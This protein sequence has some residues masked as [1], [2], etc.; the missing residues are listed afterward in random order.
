[1]EKEGRIF[2]AIEKL[3]RVFGYKLD[4]MSEDITDLTKDMVRTEEN[5][6][7]TNELRD[8]ATPAQFK[9]GFKDIRN[10]KEN[11]QKILGA[12]VVINMLLGSVAWWVGKKFF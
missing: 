3:E 2:E 9:A 5:R 1:M 12:L 6:K 11:K 7:F 4:K 10:L 8:I